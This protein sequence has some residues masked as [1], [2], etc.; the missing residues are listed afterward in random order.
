LKWKPHAGEHARL[1]PNDASSYEARGDK[2]SIFR[3]TLKITTDIDPRDWNW[4]TL[5]AIDPAHES[6]KVESVEVLS[7]D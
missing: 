6:V 1:A 7:D 2:M 4:D 5:L 3:V